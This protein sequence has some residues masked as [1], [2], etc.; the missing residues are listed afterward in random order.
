MIKV[1]DTHKPSNREITLYFECPDSGAEGRAEVRFVGPHFE[2]E[3]EEVHWDT[4]PHEPSN[5]GVL[6]SDQMYDDIETAA[7]QAWDFYK[8][9]DS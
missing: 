6:E 7:I 9:Y 8:E 4:M 5:Y 3:V 2:V 1:I